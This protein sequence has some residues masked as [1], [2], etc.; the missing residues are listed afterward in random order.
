MGLPEKGYLKILAL[1][2][3]AS[4]FSGSLF[5][6]T[7]RDT[8]Y[9]KSSFLLLWPPPYY[10][11]HLLGLAEASVLAKQETAAAHSFPQQDNKELHHE[12][13]S[14]NRTRHLVLGRRTFGGDA[15]F[16]QTLTEAQM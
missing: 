10:A 3:F 6:I 11:C 4:L 2:K 12:K 7:P 1:Q 14:Q 8:C 9:I 5:I 15:V 13:L 16:G